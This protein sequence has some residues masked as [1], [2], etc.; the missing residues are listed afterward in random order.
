MGENSY[1]TVS[2]KKILGFLEENHD[3]TVTASDIDA[4]LREQNSEVNITTIYRYLDKLVKEETVIKYVA[5]KGSQAAY[6]YVERGHR[7]DEH[8]HLKCVR[9]GR[10]IHLECDFMQEISEHIRKD[11]GFELQ[12]K[13]SI[14][15]GLCRE[16]KTKE[17]GTESRGC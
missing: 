2:R 1:A 13:N 10:I 15:Y 3:R 16:C 12:C 7:C 6:Q 5:E 11:H 8:L 14:L 4:Y 9:C 17:Q